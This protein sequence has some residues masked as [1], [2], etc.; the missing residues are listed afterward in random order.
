MHLRRA[1]DGPLAPTSLLRH[2]ALELRRPVLHVMHPVR[3]DA[4][5]AQLRND[6]TSV[7]SDVVTRGQS[8]VT[9]VQNGLADR[10]RVSR[11]RDRD[12]EK[13]VS[14]DEVKMFTVAGPAGLDAAADG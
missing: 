9:E 4:V 12:A 13:A 10:E 3:A 7:R 11:L 6:D 2:P 14:L 1:G 8:G 5:G